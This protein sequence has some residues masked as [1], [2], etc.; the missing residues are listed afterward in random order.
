MKP[1]IQRKYTNVSHPV[2]EMPSAEY[3]R[4]IMVR[5][6]RQEYY[7]TQ[8]IPISDQI[9]QE[10]DFEDYL[11]ETYGM[12][13]KYGYALGDYDIIDESKHLLFLMKYAR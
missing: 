2:D 13:I 6:C 8:G 9:Y 12:I 1:V 4:W 10:S 3:R 11:R 7:K 5:A